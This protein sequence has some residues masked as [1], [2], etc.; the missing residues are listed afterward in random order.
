MISVIY[1]SRN[2]NSSYK[3]EVIVK[4]SLEEATKASIEIAKKTNSNSVVLSPACASFDQ[5]ENYEERGDHFKR[6]VKKLG[7]I[8]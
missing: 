6:I 4:Q 2:S 3:G 7:I 5:Y 8:K 1:K